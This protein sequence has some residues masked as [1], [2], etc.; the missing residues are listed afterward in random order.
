MDLEAFKDL[1]QRCRTVSRVFVK[2]D[3][4]ARPGMQGRIPDNLWL[5]EFPL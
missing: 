1:V 5:K 2:Q 4:G 3:S